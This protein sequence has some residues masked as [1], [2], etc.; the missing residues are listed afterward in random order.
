MIVEVKETKRIAGQQSI[1]K[2]GAYYYSVNSVKNPAVDKTFIV[3]CDK[4]GKIT[5]W[6]EVYTITPSNHEKTIEALEM[7]ALSSADFNF[8]ERTKR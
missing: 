3:K 4:Y 8:V 2:D 7:G 1:V 5:D 6:N